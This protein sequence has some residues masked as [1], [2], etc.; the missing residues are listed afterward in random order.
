M[1]EGKLQSARML[2]IGLR[3][4]ALSSFLLFQGSEAL[5]VSIFL[6]GETYAAAIHFY[7]WILPLRTEKV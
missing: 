6:W 7:P 4:S 5:L 2:G 3:A 1:P